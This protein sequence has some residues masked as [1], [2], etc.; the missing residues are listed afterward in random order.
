MK[1]KEN[2]KSSRI[3]EFFK[4]LEEKL[5]TIHNNKYDYGETVYESSKKNFSYICKKHGIVNQKAQEHI[6]GRGC[7]KCAVEYSSNLL[8]ENTEKNLIN[9]FIEVHGKKYSYENVIYK[10]GI[11]KVKINCK[12]HGEFEQRPDDHKSGYGCP[13][14][15]KEHK[16]Y[17]LKYYIDKSNIIH[18]NKYTYNILKHKI[19]NTEKVDVFCNLHGWFNINAKRHINGHGC[20]L[21]LNKDKRWTK[22][23]YDGNK[24]ILYYVKIGKYYKIGLTKRTISKRFETE[25]DLRKNIEIIN[26]WEFKNGGIAFEIEN[27]CLIATKKYST[28]HKLLTRGGNSELRTVNVYEIIKPIIENAFS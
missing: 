25:T 12:F 6:R 1:L 17:D 22:K 2:T 28:K 3:I 19:L 27:E 18:N 24:T 26:K 9:K 11:T 23:Y 7:K 4:T 15:A 20:V 10:N 21:C 5:N 16:A 14:C 8:L 13:K